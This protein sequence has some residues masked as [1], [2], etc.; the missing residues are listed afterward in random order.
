MLGSVRAKTGHGVR[1]L[2]LIVSFSVQRNVRRLSL[3]GRPM[4]ELAR[5]LAAAR[6]QFGNS[7]E[8]PR[9]YQSGQRSDRMR[10]PLKRAPPDVWARCRSKMSLRPHGGAK[11]VALLQ[12][13]SGIGD[14]AE[15]SCSQV[16]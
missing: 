1:T 5:L 2:Q 13:P 16:E 12:E 10:L 4:F 3:V 14:W 6:R 15:N 7:P 11:I 8:S 9:V